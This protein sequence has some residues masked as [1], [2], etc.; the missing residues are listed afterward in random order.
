MGSENSRRVE[1]QRVVVLNAS[2]ELLAVVTVPRAVGYL[3]L[4]KAEVVTNCPSAPLRSAGGFEMPVPAVVRLVRYVRIP[5]KSLVPAWT[6]NGLMCRDG[7]SCA[8]CGKKAMTVDHL[9]PT[10]RG[11]RSTWMNTVAACSRCNGRKADRTP[12]EAGMTLRFGPTEPTM[13]SAMMFKLRHAE[14]QALV[15]IGLA[16]A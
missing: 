6:H 1:T 9:L 15:D 14:V 12:D 11:G 5:V 4:E 2:Y 8:Y 13:K 10:S 3:M 7:H 16:V